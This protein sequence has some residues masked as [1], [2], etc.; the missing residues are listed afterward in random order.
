MADYNITAR[1]KKL[2]DLTGRTFNRLTVIGFSH[3]KKLRRYWSCLCTCGKTTTAQTTRL[4]SG[5]TKSCGCLRD[6]TRRKI[7]NFHCKIHPEYS[8]WIGI[9]KRCFKKDYPDYHLYGGRGIA[10]CK[11]WAADFE[12]FFRDMGPRPSPKHSIDRID[13]DGNYEPGNC[14]WATP[15]EQNYNRRVNRFVTIGGVTRR[16]SDWCQMFGITP[17][18][19]NSRIVRYGWDEIRAIT[20]PV[21]KADRMSGESNPS[22]KLSS[23]DVIEIRRLVAS[24]KSKTSVAKQFAIHFSSVKRIVDRKLWVNV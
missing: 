4:I 23:S 15:K 18:I 12:T 7:G 5:N 22:H 20:T 14:R 11:Q 13:N 2:P 17:R 6:E 3:F 19:A 8:V 1:G 9:K 16:I 10:I 24:G 21:M